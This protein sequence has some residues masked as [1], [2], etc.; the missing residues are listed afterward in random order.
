IPHYS[1]EGDDRFNQFLREW[2]I[3]KANRIPDELAQEPSP[4]LIARRDQH[5]VGMCGYSAVRSLVH[6]VY[7][8]ERREGI[9]RLLMETILA[10]P[11]ITFPVDAHVVETN[12]GAIKFYEQLGFRD[13]GERNIWHV[14][15]QSGLGMQYMNMRLDQPLAIDLPADTL[16]E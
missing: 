4:Y 11:E 16:P 2:F 13:T 5:V 1:R 10:A 6:S 12:T 7:V 3:R 9:G 14:D 15:E 8:S